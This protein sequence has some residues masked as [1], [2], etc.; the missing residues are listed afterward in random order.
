MAGVSILASPSACC[1]ILGKSPGLDRLSPHFLCR[2]GVK[3]PSTLTSQHNGEQ[4]GPQAIKDQALVVMSP[5]PYERSWSKCGTLHIFQNPW[6]LLFHEMT[7]T[8][9]S[10]A[11][12]CSLFKSQGRGCA[13]A[14]IFCVSPES[15]IPFSPVFSRQPSLTYEEV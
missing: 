10:E 2:L 1:L 7:E 9:R 3:A 15:Q 8:E 13:A 14:S 12:Q 11:M 5:S 6:N 4:A